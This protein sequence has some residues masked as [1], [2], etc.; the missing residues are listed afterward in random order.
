MK[1][2]EKLSVQELFKLISPNSDVH[3]EL[4]RRNILRTK[5]TTGE[6]GEYYVVQHYN[7]D[8][9][10]TNLFLPGPGVKNI[11]V[12]GRNGLKYS[13]KT[14][15]GK[16]RSTGSFWRP[17]LIDRNEKTFDK[18]IICILNDDY[19]V[20]MI[21]EMDWEDFM[22]YKKFNTRMKNYKV[23]ITKKMINNVR[24]IYEKK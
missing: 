9:N 2:L 4:K 6:I 8:S 15:S 14:V 18:L 3:Q 21:L 5:N 20:E 13:I 10:L 7:N 1:E 16:N 23:P 11:D 22:K 24:V 12:V 17:D 19:V